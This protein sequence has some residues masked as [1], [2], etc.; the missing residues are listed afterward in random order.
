MAVLE[1]WTDMIYTVRV[2]CRVQDRLVAHS[3]TRHDLQQDL[4]LQEEEIRL[5]ETV[6]HAKDA[7]VPATAATAVIATEVGAQAEVEV[8]TGLVLGG[9]KKDKD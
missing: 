7:V 8:E 3:P 1:Q 4:L 2:P 6:P 5:D 9:D